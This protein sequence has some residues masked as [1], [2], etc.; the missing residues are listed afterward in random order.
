MKGRSESNC[1]GDVVYSA[2]LGNEKIRL[3]LDRRRIAL[4]LFLTVCP[5]FTQS[6]Y[7]NTKLLAVKKFS[8]KSSCRKPDFSQIK[9]G[10]MVI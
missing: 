9:D 5:A 10:Q 3:K 1:R 7:D 8:I 4:I 2:T 6:F